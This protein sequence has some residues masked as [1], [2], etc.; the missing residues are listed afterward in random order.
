MYKHLHYRDPKATNPGM[1]D[2]L[3]ILRP[4]HDGPRHCNRRQ[5][6]AKPSHI[7]DAFNIIKCFVSHYDPIEQIR[8][9]PFGQS[10]NFGKPSPVPR[11]KVARSS[12]TS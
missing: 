7:R 12:T 4:T 5:Q 3:K 2:K 6:Q 1:A 10:L 11:V 8:D 9:G